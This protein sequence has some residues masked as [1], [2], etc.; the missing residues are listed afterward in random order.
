MDQINLDD[1]LASFS[2]HWQPRTAAQFNGHD[3][4]VVKAK[5]DFGHAT[6]DLSRVL[7]R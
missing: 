1:K 4:M 7:A 6:A 5:G 2:E 3:V